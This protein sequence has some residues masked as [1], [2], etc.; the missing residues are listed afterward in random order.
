MDLTLT[1]ESILLIHRQMVEEGLARWRLDSS[2]RQRRTVRVRLGG[3][4]I[5]LGTRMKGPE[6]SASD[7]AG[8]ARHDPAFGPG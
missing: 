2:P 5:A 8:A 1:P 6:R 3:A 4:L 7:I